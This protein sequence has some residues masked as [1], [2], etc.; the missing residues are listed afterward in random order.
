MLPGMTH[1]CIPTL[2]VLLASTTPPAARASV[3]QLTT[4][5]ATEPAA[6]AEWD[7]KVIRLIRL[8]HLKLREQQP[9]DDGARVDEWYVQVHEGVPILG[10]EVWRERE[11]KTTTAITGSIYTAVDLS[12]K[13]RL[14]LDEAR[15]V[16][17]G[18]AKGSPGP[19][20]PPT[21]AIL[22]QPDQFLLVY[23][24]RVLTGTELTLFSIDAVTGE[25]VS[26]ETDLEPS[27]R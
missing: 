7:R 17:I 11:G 4:I 24:A 6:V 16:F 13:A 27:A 12:V 1:L 21:L 19:S 26:A 15:V 25:V 5:D 14:S 3:P 9:S 23:Q 20:Q 8:G 2:A 22:P 18:L 10:T